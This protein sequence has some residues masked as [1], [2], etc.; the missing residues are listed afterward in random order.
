M[1]YVIVL[2]NEKGGSGKSTM[3]MHVMTALLRSGHAVAALDLDL[4]QGS[5][6]RYVRNREAYVA[7]EGVA[8]PLPV[9]V[10][11]TKSTRDS[12]AQGRVEEEDQFAQALTQADQ[13]ADV[14]V[15]DCP[16]A[17]SYYAQMAHSA[18][19]TLITP[20][21]DSLIDFDLLANIDPKTEKVLG[22]SVY[23]EMV[24]K[25]RQLRAKAGLRPVDWLVVRNRMASLEARNRRKVS[26]ALEE[27]SSRVDFRLAP[28]F[29]E[30]VIFRELF[31]S[32]LTLLDLRDVG[33]MRFSMSNVAARQELRDLMRALNLPEHLSTN[34]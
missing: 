11:V 10:E 15:I 31:L 28:G 4:R 6:R 13:A 21:N 20:M 14:I 34:V 30:R 1:A 17:H 29:S 22:P 12:V 18:A 5:L 8:L 32:G 23:A 3:A 7:R 2:G 25:A 26:S 27:I 16:G 33:A 24:W 9:L 19:D